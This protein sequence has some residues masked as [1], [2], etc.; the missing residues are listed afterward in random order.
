MEEKKTNKNALRSRKLIKQGFA[1]L[2][3]ERKDTASITITDIVNAAGVNRAT[4][5]A[6]YSCIKDLTD[7]IEQEVTDK[8]MELLS[9][10]HFENFSQNP[11]PLLLQVSIF[12]AENEDYYRTLINAP[13]AGKFID[14]LMELFIQYL[15]SDDSIP[16]E[17][18]ESK[19]FLLRACYFAGG[20]SSMYLE[21]F[22]GKLDC[23]LYDIPAEVGILCKEMNM[24]SLYERVAKTPSKTGNH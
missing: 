8:L 6:H 23:T 24:K 14:K 21:W 13:E 7:E 15:K 12:L 4:F 19:P 3:K 9:Q 2:L 17:V 11:T 20:L 22:K 18:R 16:K 5:Y 10:F 1:S